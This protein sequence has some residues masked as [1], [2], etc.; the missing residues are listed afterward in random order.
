MFIVLNPA[1]NGAGNKSKTHVKNYIGPSIT[2]L[3]GIDICR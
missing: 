3:F 2:I 1:F